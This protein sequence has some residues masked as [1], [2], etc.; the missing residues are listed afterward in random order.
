[1]SYIRSAGRRA[2][3]RNQYFVVLLLHETN[4]NN[5]TKSPCGRKNT[6]KLVTL[7]YVHVFAFSSERTINFYL[8]LFSHFRPAEQ[9][10]DKML[11]LSYFRVVFFA[12]LF[13]LRR[14]S[15]TNF[16]NFVRR[17]GTKQPVSSLL[18]LII[19]RQLWHQTTLVLSKR[20]TFILSTNTQIHFATFNIS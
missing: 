7:S 2:K 18:C 15:T 16:R 9:K 20:R 10:Y 19:F 1:M 11:T 4:H 5:N 13:P 12:H 6:I 17:P 8:F 3:T 14:E